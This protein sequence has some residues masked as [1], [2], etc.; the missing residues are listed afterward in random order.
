MH[1]TADDPLFVGRFQS[2]QNS[3]GLPQGARYDPF[4]PGDERGETRP[5]L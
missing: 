3:G 5:R 4:Y 2:V 1:P